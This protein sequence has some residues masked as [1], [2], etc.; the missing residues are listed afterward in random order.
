[1]ISGAFQNDPAR[2]AAAVGS[3]GATLPLGIVALGRSAADLAAALQDA[4]LA[5]EQAGRQWQDRF[6]G[7][8]LAL[9]RM[10][11][12]IARFAAG[13]QELGRFARSLPE[14]LAARGLLEER[15]ARLGGVVIDL[16]STQQRLQQLTDRERAGFETRRIDSHPG[17][18]DTDRGARVGLVTLVALAADDVQRAIDVGHEIVDAGKAVAAALRTL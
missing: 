10:A 17:D 4:A 18:L 9:D 2:C 1:M 15:A 3:Y 14:G 12:G 8:E 16:A 6:R 13:Q 7:F 5:V 11:A